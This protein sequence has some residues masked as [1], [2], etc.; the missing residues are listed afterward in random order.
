MIYDHEIPVVS[1]PAGNCYL[2]FGKASWDGQTDVVK[3][4]WRDRNGHRSRPGGEIWMEALAQTFTE[5]L[6]LGLLSHGR[7]AQALAEGMS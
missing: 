1:D 5:A 6:R 7:A 3:L 2:A 4:G